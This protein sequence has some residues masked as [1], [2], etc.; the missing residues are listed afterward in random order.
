MKTIPYQ[1]WIDY[2]E[3]LVR[4]HR[5]RVDDVLD[6]A[7]G[8]GN[9]AIPWAERGYRVFGVDISDQM[10]SVAEE[11]TRARGLEVRYVRQDMR[12]LELNHQF[13]LVTC[14]Y[15]SMNYVLT[16]DGLQQVFTGVLEHLRD[17]GLFVFDMNSR[18]KLSSIP[19][20]TIHLQDDGWHLIWEETFDAD[21][22]EWRVELTGFIAVPR[23]SE[24]YRGFSELHRERGYRIEQVQ[25]LLQRSGFT[26][27]HAY[28]AFTHYRANESCERIYYAAK[29]KSGV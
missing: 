6:L 28:K 26:E 15:D 20:N 22:E 9:S 29:K 27:V 13:D 14:L 2:V 7:C 12:Q 17:G 23:S 3:G 8:T 19:D 16:V 21:S 11:K 5:V 10:L 24:L 18:N 25:R 1:Q 4:K